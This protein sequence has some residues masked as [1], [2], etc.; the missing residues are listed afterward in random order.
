MTKNNDKKTM[1]KYNDQKITT[2]N[3]DKNND[4]N[5][6]KKTGFRI[7]NIAQNEIEM[8]EIGSE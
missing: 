7:E 4:K 8:L 6:D 3:E 2:N 5:N 1:T